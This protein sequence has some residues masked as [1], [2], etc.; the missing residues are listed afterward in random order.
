MTFLGTR[1]AQ[2]CQSPALGMP[3]PHGPRAVTLGAV[4][5]EHHLS[6]AE[7]CALVRRAFRPTAA[8]R[9][10]AVITDL[11]AT[12]ADDR[13]AWR[14]RRE[15]ARDWARRLAG[16]RDELGL[17]TDFYLYHAVAANN[18]DLP[19]AAWPHRGERLP[20]TARE[21]DAA[22]T[23]PFE[24]VFEGHSILIAP[25]ELSATAPLKLAAPRYGFRA[26]TMPGFQSAMIPALRLDFAEVDRRVRHLKSLLD[27]ASAAYF[28][29]ETN[30][31][32]AMLEL[33]LRYRTAH[34]SSGLL[35]EPGTAG[36]LPSGEAYIV[37]YEGERE[38]EPSR[39]AGVLPVQLGDEVV[40]YRIEANRAV[41]VL[42]DGPASR[43]QAAYLAREPAYGNVA[44]LGLGVLA[45]LGVAPIGEILIDE[46][47]GL[48]I[49][50]GR[51]DHFGGQVGAAQFS[52]PSAAVHVDRV[53]LSE[54]QPKVQ[55]RSLVLETPGGRTM[56]LMRDQ[57]YAL[58]P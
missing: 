12:E 13:P 7:L 38:G 37:P 10:L 46:K 56:P 41:A 29:F 33:D 40:S 20:A 30:A 3:H 31:G 4:M 32:T 50:F 23:L 28:R 55:V 17:D 24:T 36:N 58:V 52:S 18:A 44:E 43:E 54:T 49:A 8:D 51:S 42:S 53:Y 57:R 27:D 45:E 14:Q 39:S 16:C 11:P 47:L 6:D 19:P 1:R 35:A 15:L 2:I 25:T 26:A 48:H 5:P 21:L 22:T 9:A 34:A